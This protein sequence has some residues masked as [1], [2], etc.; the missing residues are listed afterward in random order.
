MGR[1]IAAAGI[2]AVL[3]LAGCGGDDESDG[4]T[5]SPAA[6]ADTPMQTPGVPAGSAY[7]V[8]GSEWLELDAAE[9]DRAAADF[10][11]DNPDACGEEDPAAT[12]AT[13]RD[14][15]AT[16]LGTDYPLNAP[17]AELLAEGCAAAMQSG[18]GS[19]QG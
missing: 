16:T 11:A 2:L 3:L 9:R 1:S 14:Y 19:G 10:V 5:V 18:D 7:D 13:V 4:P 17:V 12:A 8:S 6:G 15:A